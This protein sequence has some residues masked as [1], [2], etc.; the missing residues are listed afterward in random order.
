[1]IFRILGSGK[2]GKI[3]SKHEYKDFL[4]KRRQYIFS[5]NSGF[6]YRTGR[7]MIKAL[8]WILNDHASFLSALDCFFFPAV[9]RS[10]NSCLL[11]SNKRILAAMAEFKLS[12]PE[13]MGMES[14]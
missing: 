2:G 14:L 4:L 10:S 5:L 7:I 9:C 11:P 12:T 1:M 8:S 3:S 13:T 6:Y